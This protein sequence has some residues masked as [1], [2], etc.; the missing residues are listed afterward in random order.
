[1]HAVLAALAFFSLRTGGWLRGRRRAAPAAL[2]GGAQLA[3]LAE[4]KEPADMEAGTSQDEESSGGKISGWRQAWQCVCCRSGRQQ[5]LI[6]GL[7]A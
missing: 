4:G 5:V 1:M 2:P 6:E 7:H 3:Q